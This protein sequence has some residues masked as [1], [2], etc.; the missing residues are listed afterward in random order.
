MTRRI[1]SSMSVWLSE[2]SG[3]LRAVLGLRAFAIAASSAAEL[4]LRARLRALI[5]FFER[6]GALQP[7]PFQPPPTGQSSTIGQRF[8]RAGPPMTRAPSAEH[9]QQG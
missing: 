1:Q 3:G 6:A 7:R 9:G 8:V 2:G 5:P 4:V